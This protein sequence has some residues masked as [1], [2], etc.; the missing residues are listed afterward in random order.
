MSEPELT[1][2]PDTL[3]AI[4]DRCSKATWQETWKPIPRNPHYE[5]SDFGNVR[6]WLK[7][8]NHKSKRAQ[9]WRL[10]KASPRSPDGRRYV[11][12]SV[13][14]SYYHFSVGRLVLEAFVGPRPTG[15]EAA[16]LNGDASDDRL[17][18]L[19]YCTHI[20]NESHK[21]AH[22]TVAT[23]EK[24]GQAKLQGWQVAEIKFLADKSLPF[25]KIA[26]LF[27]MNPKDVSAIV[28][29]G[30]WES[31]SARTDIPA[32]VQDVK[33]LT[34]KLAERD[35]LLIAAMHALRSYQH[36]NSSPDLAEEIANTIQAYLKK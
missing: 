4:E 22:G 25:G 20:E 1:M 12:I 30:A 5:V 15:H 10:L 28:N 6:S 27:D 32:L 3:Q 8:G 19:K 36:R 18:N 11:S 24:N 2:T 14:G 35:K 26:T 13:D 21:V 33:R 31:V 34:E 16:H 9:N 17:V 23:G 29:G 7:H